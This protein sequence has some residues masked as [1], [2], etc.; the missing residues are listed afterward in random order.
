MMLHN[1]HWQFLQAGS[2]ETTYYYLPL[3]G[4]VCV[5]MW[6]EKLEDARPPVIY[7]STTNVY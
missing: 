7:C 5:C 3:S 4:S 1:V 2:F 6:M